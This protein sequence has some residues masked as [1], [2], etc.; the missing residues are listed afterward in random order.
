MAVYPVDDDRLPMNF[1]PRLADA[2]DRSLIQLLIR[3][4]RRIRVALGES[5]KTRYSYPMQAGL[6]LPPEQPSD[7]GV[8][9]LARRAA[10]LLSAAGIAEVPCCP[11]PSGTTRLQPPRM[12]GLR[13]ARHGRDSCG[14]PTTQA[15]EN[16]SWFHRA[17]VR[18]SRALRTR[19]MYGERQTCRSS[20]G[21]T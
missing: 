13:E 1:G 19:G 9:E 8:E 4:V 5:M 10:G 21:H 12:N 11:A 6:G 7:D 20:K 14:R 3:V 18:R 16:A 15:S 2:K 17:L